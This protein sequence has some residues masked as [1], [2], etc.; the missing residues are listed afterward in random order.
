MK[1]NVVDNY[2]RAYGDTKRLDSSVEI[3]VVDR[4]FVM[5]DTRGRIRNFVSEKSNSIESRYRFESINR[6]ARPSEDCRAHS[7]RR[8]DRRKS[9]IRSPTDIETPIGRVVIH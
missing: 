3:L 2:S 7:H 5:P 1:F 4:V 6:C 9:E 8:T